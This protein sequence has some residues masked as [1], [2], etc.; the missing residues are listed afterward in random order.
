[1]AKPIKKNYYTVWT[2]N[3]G[4]FIKHYTAYEV[5]EHHANGDIT[6]YKRMK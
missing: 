4:K 1:M 3:G 2:P 6:K 5:R